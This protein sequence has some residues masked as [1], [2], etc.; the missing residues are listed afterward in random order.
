[1]FNNR[2]FCTPPKMFDHSCFVVVLHIL[3]QDA[4]SEKEFKEVC[5]QP[6]NVSVEM[7]RTAMNV[8]PRIRKPE[9]HK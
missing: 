2:C 5:E 6:M 1:M 8:F 7:H 4:T 3:K 9:N